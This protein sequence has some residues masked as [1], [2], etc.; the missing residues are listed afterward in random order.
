MKSE[1]AIVVAL[2]ALEWLARDEFRFGGFLAQGGM[3]LSDLA[4]NAA[5]PEF[6]AALVDFILGD[7]ASVIAF[8]RD[9]G[10]SPEILMQ[11]RSGLPGGQLPHWT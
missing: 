11:A 4:A 5:D 10:F 7:E 6:L 2:Q 1:Q 9:M 3:A 8:A